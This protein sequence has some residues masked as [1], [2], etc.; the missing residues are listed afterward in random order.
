MDRRNFN[1]LL[2]GTLTVAGVPRIDAAEK[3]SA[4]AVTSAKPALESTGSIVSDVSLRSNNN[5]WE[6]VI[7]DAAPTDAMQDIGGTA[8]GDIDKDGRTEVVIAGDGGLLWYRP[9]TAEKGIIA[10]GRF[11]VGLVLGDIDNDGRL[12]VIATEKVVEPGQTREKWVIW[13]YKSGANL[14]DPWTGH[15]ADSETAGNPH[16]VVFADLD[17]DGKDELIATA[18]Y[19][20]TPGLY[21]YKIPSN[22]KE[23]WKKQVIQTGLSAEGTSAGDLNG[24]GKDEIVCGPYWFSAPRAGA[25]SGEPWET[26]TVAPGFR[27]MCRSAIIDVNG[28]GHLDIVIVEDEYPDGRL[29]WFENRLRNAPDAGWIEHPISAPLNFP[30]TLQAWRDPK[31]RQAHLL[32]G[33]MNEG[34]WVAPY[35]WNARLIIYTALEGGKSWSGDLIYQGEGTHQ[36]VYA[37]LDGSGTHVIFG[38][39]AQVIA[40]NGSYTGWVQMFRPQKAPSKLEQYKH[41]FVDRQKPYTGIDIHAVDLSGDGQ[42][43][44]VCGAWWYENPTWNRHPIPGI[45]QIINAYDVDNDGRKELIG[46]KGK[47][48]VKDF[49]GALNS[50]LGGSVETLWAHLPAEPG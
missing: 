46:I 3:P 22:P 16:D 35:N 40:K 7:L 23:P 30:H 10:H 14:H 41:T 1:K 5:S 24:D 33:E 26:H 34:G 4:L 48:G 15:I 49:Y 11:G 43:D 8:V 29:S 38:H 9:S 25:F 21:A 12:E 39:S 31:T 6:L 20:N 13:W 2:A 47:P 17:G 19:S 44:I 45:A 50:D 32:I 42:A 37:E 18:M 27:E 28:D 36:G